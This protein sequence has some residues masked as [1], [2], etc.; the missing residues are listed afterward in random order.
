MSINRAELR[1]EAKFQKSVLPSVFP[2]DS[3]V[4]Y[5]LAEPFLLKF[6]PNKLRRRFILAENSYI[7]IL[8]KKF[9][10]NFGQKIR[11]FLKKRDLFENRY[12][13]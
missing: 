8:T 4:S 12:F 13:C 10:I 11:F 9:H 6:E 7:L 5:T 3:P 1:L 2:F